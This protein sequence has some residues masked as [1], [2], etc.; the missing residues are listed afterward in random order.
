M[1][2]GQ[3]RDRIECARRIERHFEYAKT[4]TGKCRADGVDFLRRD[5]AQYGNQR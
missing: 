5:T 4:G 1:L 3:T 2:R